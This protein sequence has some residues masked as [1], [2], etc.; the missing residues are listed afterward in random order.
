[1]FGKNIDE[2]YTEEK[3]LY[4][5]QKDFSK[6]AYLSIYDKLIKIQEEV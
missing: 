1:V 5:I 6:E 2:D 4:T 3:Y